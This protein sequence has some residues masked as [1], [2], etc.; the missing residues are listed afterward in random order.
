MGRL[1]KF[2][3][4]SFSKGLFACSFIFKRKSEEN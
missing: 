2:D 4:I 1:A 3:G